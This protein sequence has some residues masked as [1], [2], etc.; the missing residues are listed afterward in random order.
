MSRAHKIIRHKDRNH[1]QI[2]VSCNYI[3]FCL[4]SQ[5]LHDTVNK[6]GVRKIHRKHTYRNHKSMAIPIVTPA[7]QEY[8][9]IVVVKKIINLCA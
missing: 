5:K 1:V 6:K 8:L 2:Q 9:S 3:R 7:F 4:Q